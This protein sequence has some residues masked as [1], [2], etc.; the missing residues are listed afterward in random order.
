MSKFFIKHP[1]IAMVISIIMVLLGGL[2]MLS[3]PI[4]Q[5]PDIVP[6]NIM[7]QATYPG[8]DAQTVTDSVASP[9]EQQMSGVDNMEYMQSTNSN[10]GISS[11]QVIF[12]V[13]TDPNID[14][15]LTYMRY[16]QA[17][18][19]LPSEVSQMGVTLSKAA[20]APL[21]VLS[22]YSPDDSLNPIF[23]A[24]YAHVSLVDP[25]KR[26]PGVGNVQVFGTGRYAMRIWLD[27]NRMAAQ[28]ITLSEVQAAISAQNTVNP[29]G[30]VGAEP[31]LPGQDFTYT[32]RTKG[33]LT[34][35]EEF[36]DIIIRAVDNNFIYLKDIARIELGAQTYTPN[37]LYNGK[38]TG[39][40]AIYQT[41][42][43]NAI[44]TVDAVNQMMKEYERSFPAGLTYK[45]SMDTTTAV[46]ASIEEI[47]HT[48]VEALILV[49]IVVFVFLQG[50]RAT[51]IPA[52]AVPV[53]I[54]GTFM[55]FPLIGF[56]LNTICLMGMVLAIGLVVDDA[57]VVV[58]AVESHMERGLTPRQAAFAA[59]EEVSG[60]V[61]AIALVLA[62]VFL[63]SLMLSGITG[64]LFQQFAVTIAISMLI[65]AFNALTLSPALSAI[66]LKPKSQTH[67]LLT[68]FYKLFNK[69]YELT[70]NGYT[71][72]CR[73]LTR[74]L[75]ISIPFL[76]II[77]ACIY[78]VAKDIPGGFLPDEDQGYLFACV[79]LP[80]ASS[81]QRTK[82][83]VL[84][85]DSLLRANP[86]VE[87]VTGVIGF[88]MITGVQSTNC[89]FF[90]IK[91]KNWDERQGPG[92][93]AKD[94]N[95]YFNGLLTTKISEGIAFCF[96]PPAIA[97][98]G[99]ANG[100]T[101]ILQDRAG[102]GSTYLDE[103]TKMFVD[104]VS[105]RPEIGSA[106]ST[107]MSAVPQIRANLDIAKCYTHGVDVK[108]A[109]NLL[110]AYM[111][112]LFLNYIT[113]YGQQWQVY[114]QAQADDRS[115]IKDLDNY[116]LRNKNGVAVPLSALVTREDITGPEFVFRF[117]L[118][119]SAQ[120]QVTPAA[121][122]SNT[123]AMEA[124]EE[125]FYQIMPNDMGFD[126]A[127]MSFQENKVRN[128]IS[129]T[130]IFAISAVFVFLILAA[131]YERWTLPL[132]IFLTIPI[133]AL[134]AIL[135]LWYFGYEMNLYA[136]IGLVMLIGLAAKNAILIVE[137]AII[138]IERGKSLFDATISAAKIRLRPILMTS[139]A[140][141]LGCVPLA[142]ASG[143]GAYSRNI[144]G[145]VVIAGMGLATVLGVFLIPCSFYF[146]MRL[147]RVKISA[148]HEGDDP[149][150]V[151]AMKHLQGEHQHA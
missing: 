12:K 72:V 42:G 13:G 2:S 73:F 99:A 125:V 10:N 23:L 76:A 84:K 139:F 48:L 77:C 30:Q 52:I 144:I 64:T 96:E 145:I 150:E 56:T 28:N 87:D 53:S 129:I 54:I 9:I 32:V 31:A 25:I 24:N 6:P 36:G 40:I 38:P 74:R 90:F 143:S 98:I 44:A 112:S 8:A 127:G 132:S 100:V 29:S 3:L 70:A 92:Q 4:E 79:Q 34:T 109:N 151:I 50:W 136:Q 82:D 126:Y 18:A 89:G 116:Y 62:A 57:I 5:Y 137:F 58:E 146:I 61:I 88:N 19:Q 20:T 66:L 91:L 115:D 27:T 39:A 51:L 65:S 21:C 120:L 131:L 110:Q 118:Y 106:R 97:G 59:M 78:P 7:L 107:L 83:V 37:A 1:V 16:G 41:P 68:P 33:R 133:A 85:I 11:M 119:N 86:A 101:F 47:K 81:A 102:N 123:Q 75:I 103:Q 117:N 147:F 135:G 35:P 124:L 69:S 80:D 49:V 104:A 46:R 17:T 45:M 105:K 114:L 55:I 149:D 60:P 14:Q 22:L 26:L 122:Y 43:S 94:L 138:E 141:I 67:S 111:G 142:I 108:E 63:P 93:S 15:T 128:G 134:G 95:G 121:G 71:G 140:F 148:K 130:D 113:L